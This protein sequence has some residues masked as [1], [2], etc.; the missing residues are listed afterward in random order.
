MAYRIRLTDSERKAA[1]KMAGLTRLCSMPIAGDRGYGDSQKE[2][3]ETTRQEGPRDTDSRKKS[4]K[5]H[6]KSYGAAQV[7]SDMPAPIEEC[8][9]Q[10]FGSRIWSSLAGLVPFLTHYLKA[11]QIGELYKPYRI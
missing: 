1:Q 10:E 11:K 5:H 7:Y 2:P 3:L 4:P 9:I 6:I 8:T